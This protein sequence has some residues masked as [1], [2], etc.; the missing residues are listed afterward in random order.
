[1]VDRFGN[2]ERIALVAATLWKHFSTYNRTAKGIFVERLLEPSGQ[3]PEDVAAHGVGPV[4]DGQGRDRRDGNTG[5]ALED[6]DDIIVDEE[7]E[8]VDKQRGDETFMSAEDKSLQSSK[9]KTRGTKCARRFET[10]PVTKLANSVRPTLFAN[11]PVVKLAVAEDRQIKSFVSQLKQVVLRSRLYFER[12]GL[13]PLEATQLMFSHPWY[14]IRL[15]VI[16]K[17]GGRAGPVQPC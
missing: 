6:A 2:E 17:G 12:L 15:Q 4:A 8:M 1:M 10:G 16:H 3:I 5:S 7:M 11:I 14:V 9:G 13:S